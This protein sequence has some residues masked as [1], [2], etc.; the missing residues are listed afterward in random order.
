MSNV[1]KSIRKIVE[2]GDNKKE[3]VSKE[4]VPM[5]DEPSTAVS[6]I[7]QIATRSLIDVVKDGAFSGLS[8]EQRQSATFRTGTVL[9]ASVFEL[10]KAFDKKID[11]EQSYKRGL[12]GLI[13]LFEIGFSAKRV[14]DGLQHNDQLLSNKKLEDSDIIEEHDEN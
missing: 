14:L 3:V 11:Q 6:P 4:K 8:E 9:G 5:K 12:T 7:D 13:G 2:S 10:G 1:I